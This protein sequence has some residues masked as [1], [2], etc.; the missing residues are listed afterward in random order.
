[1]VNNAIKALKERDGFSL[2]AI[3]KYI[4]ANYT[5]DAE[6]LARS[7]EKYLKS[8]VAPGALVQN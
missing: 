8:S 4:A 1:M 5:V 3:K 6:K 7:N 2:Q